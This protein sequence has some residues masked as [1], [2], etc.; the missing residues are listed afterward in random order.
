MNDRWPQQVRG[1]RLTAVSGSSMLHLCH[2]IIN[3]PPAPNSNRSLCAFSRTVTHGAGGSPLGV[4]MKACRRCKSYK[5]ESEFDPGRKLCKKC[6]NESKCYWY[7]TH[8]ERVKDKSRKYREAHPELVRAWSKARYEALGAKLR[9]YHRKHRLANIAD[10]AMG[11]KI[12]RER[13]RFHVSLTRSRTVA[14]QQ[15]FAPCTATAHEVAELW[16]G[17]CHN[18]SCGKSETIAGRLHLDH[19]H[20]TGRFRG[21]LCRGCN[22]AIGFAEDSPAKLRALAAYVERFAR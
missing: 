20:V 1:F 8:C 16:T 17:H 4:T 9:E 6:R 15:G 13:S 7:L 12:S 19:C 22:H 5:H 3:L 10:Y 18:P 21:F 2:S 11:D 14:K